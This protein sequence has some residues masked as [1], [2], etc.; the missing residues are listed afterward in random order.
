MWRFYTILYLYIYFF[1]L[2]I[3]W[4]RRWEKCRVFFVSGLHFVKAAASLPFTVFRR[5]I[6]YKSLRRIHYIYSAPVVCPCLT[7]SYV[8]ICFAFYILKTSS[9]SSSSSTLVVVVC[10]SSPE[11]SGSRSLD[12]ATIER[13]SAVVATVR[14]LSRLPCRLVFT[15]RATENAR[16]RRRSLVEEVVVD[17]EDSTR[18][19]RSL[20]AQL[21]T[22]ERATTNGRENSRWWLFA[23][24]VPQ[25]TTRFEKGG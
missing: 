20:T 10:L 11:L 7:F 8:Y 6:L 23:C 19:T 3:F 25:E 22:Y 2:G 15:H 5:I 14:S 12:F 1:K 21:R 24:A 16:R 13:V 9:S 18:R 4:K 17:D